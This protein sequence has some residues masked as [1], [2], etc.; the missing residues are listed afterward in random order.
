MTITPSPTSPGL[1][2][3]LAAAVAEVRGEISRC[4]TK[5]GLLL[6]TYSL[7]LA[8]LLAAVPGATLPPAAAVFIGVGSVGLVA[9]ML[10]VLAVVRPRIRSAARGAYLTWAAADVDQ[11]LADMQAPQA[12]DQ[13]AHLIHLASIAK[14]KFAAL[15]VAIDLTRVSLLVLAAAVVAALV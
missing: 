14:R 12:T 10:V 3:R 1:D 11:V 5:A 8:A 6:S 9:A 13:A 15:Q 4:D 2:A 7:P